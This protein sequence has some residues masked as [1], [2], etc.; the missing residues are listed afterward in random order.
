MRDPIHSTDCTCGCN[1]RCPNCDST[2]GRNDPCPECAHVDND[3][4]CTCD[5]CLMQEDES[6]EE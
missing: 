6:E 1:I 3:A 2:M 4:T 5:H